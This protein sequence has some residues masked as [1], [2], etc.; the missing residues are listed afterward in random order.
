MQSSTNTEQCI[1][2]YWVQ[3]LI[4]VYKIRSDQLLLATSQRVTVK[5]LTKS[6]QQAFNL[7]IAGSF[8]SKPKL[9]GPV[10][11]NNIVGTLK[12]HFSC[13]TLCISPNFRITLTVPEVVGTEN[14]VNSNLPF[15]LDPRSFTKMKS[16]VTDSWLLD[17]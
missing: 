1:Y 12:I 14:G 7:K 13:V 11:H 5:T 4:T 17:Y 9:E 10:Y 6:R 16:L 3:T 15:L 8:W 2:I